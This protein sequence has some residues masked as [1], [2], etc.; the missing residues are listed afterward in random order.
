MAKRK[1]KS[2]YRMNWQQQYD[3]GEGDRQQFSSRSKLTQRQVKIPAQRDPAEIDNL[4]ALPRV[5]GMV[6]GLYPGGVAVRC[7]DR[8][9]LCGVAKAFRVP[10]GAESAS[11]VAVGDLVTVALTRT[12]PANSQLDDKDRSDGMILLR[13]KRTSVLSRPQPR[14]GKRREEHET[15][16]L[17]K[18][19]VANMDVLLVV[20]ASAQPP[21]RRGLVDRFLIIAERGGMVPLLAINKIDLGLPPDGVL[22]GFEAMGLKAILVSAATRTGLEELRTALAGKRTILAGQSG[23]GKS[24]LINAI[25]PGAQAATN[26]IRMK[27]Q[28]GRHTTSSAVIYDL[29]AGGMIVDTPGVRELGVYMGVNE[30]PWYFPEF[31][32]FTAACKFRDCTHTHEPSCAVQQAVESGAIAARRYESYL[33]ILETLDE[34]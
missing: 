15:E 8:V 1:G 30:L 27:D 31:D 20:A 9:L 4:E 32:P 34:V 29:S 23:V 19:I 3:H 16:F 6:M 11:A 18:V 17:E 26:E 13:Q 14:S 5:Q 10:E 33:R 24:T 21:L 7:E 25:I 12:E 2:Q 22:E 28:R